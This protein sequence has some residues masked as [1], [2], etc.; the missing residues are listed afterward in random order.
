MITW[1]GADRLEPCMGS[2]PKLQRGKHQANCYSAFVLVICPL[3]CV[4]VIMN[5]K[6]LSI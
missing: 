3:I 4:I 6:I 1:R 5:I 2:K